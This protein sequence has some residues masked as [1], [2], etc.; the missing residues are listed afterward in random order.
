MRTYKVCFEQKYGK[1][2]KFSS[3]KISIFTA[4]KIDEYGMRKFSLLHVGNCLP[5]NH[6]DVITLKSLKILRKPAVEFYR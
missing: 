4:S 6:Y 1:Y 5:V 3:E 2:Q